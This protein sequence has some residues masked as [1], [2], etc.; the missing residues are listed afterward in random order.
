LA[1]TIA[2]ILGATFLIL[3]PDV[4]DRR[5]VQLANIGVFLVWPLISFMV[6]VRMCSPYYTSTILGTVVVAL[7]SLIGFYMVLK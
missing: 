1:T 7:F 5:D 2:Y 3:A 4:V 6:F